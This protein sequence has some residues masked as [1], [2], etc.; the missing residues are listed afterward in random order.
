MADMTYQTVHCIDPRRITERHFGGPRFA[1]FFV[2][3]PNRIICKKTGDVFD[4]RGLDDAW[5]E[6]R[7]LAPIIEGKGP[8]GLT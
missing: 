5:M 8:V 7:N 2:L 1:T 3:G 4:T 6:G